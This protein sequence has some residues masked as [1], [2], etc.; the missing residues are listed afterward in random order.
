MTI[1][2]G[3][4]VITYLAY[5]VNTIVNKNPTLQTSYTTFDEINNNVTFNIKHTQIDFMYTFEYHGN[6]ANFSYYQ[7]ERYIDLHFE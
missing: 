1:I 3:I 7:L 6:N 4:I 2:T 5:G